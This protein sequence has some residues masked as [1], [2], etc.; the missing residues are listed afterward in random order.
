MV[1]IGAAAASSAPLVAPGAMPP[2]GHGILVHELAASLR[3]TLAQRPSCV[4]IEKNHKTCRPSIGIN[5]TRE[6]DRLPIL[7]DFQR[8]E[9]MP[10]LLA[11]SEEQTASF[12]D[13]FA[14]S[15]YDQRL[16]MALRRTS[17]K[18]LVVT[19]E[20]SRF[21]HEFSHRLPSR[22]EPAALDQGGTGRCWL[23]AANNAVRGGLSCHCCCSAA[24]RVSCLLLPVRRRR[25]S[26]L[27]AFDRR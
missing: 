15:S 4:E 26:N 10:E 18:E 17:A 9:R 20:L 24:V 3:R 14:K 19:A 2:N 1:A 11:M 8:Y 5:M 16:Q 27:A 6:R 12:A 23:Y 13:D 7:G 22:A 21:T 25:A